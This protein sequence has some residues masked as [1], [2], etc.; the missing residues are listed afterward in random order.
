MKAALSAVTLLVSLALPALAYAGPS[1]LSGSINNIT[2]STGGLLIQFDAGIPDN[3]QGTPYN[4]MLI[5]E[6]NRA[7]T[8]MALTMWASGR[9]A[10]TVYTWA[11]PSAGAYC[12]VNQLDPVD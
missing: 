4:W 7:L 11:P 6:E 3:C 10:G 8:A 9:K 2:S 5:R 1:W 12:I